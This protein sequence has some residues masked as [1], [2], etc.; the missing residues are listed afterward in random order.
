M[1]PFRPDTLQDLETRPDAVGDRPLH[2]AA[3]TAP[4]P[5]APCPVQVLLPLIRRLFP[6]GCE[7][8][9]VQHA[10]LLAARIEARVAR[11]RAEVIRTR[12]GTATPAVTGRLEADTTE[13]GD[14]LLALAE[15][16]DAASALVLLDKAGP[17]PDLDRLLDSGVPELR[18]AALDA[19]T[20]GAADRFDRPCRDACVAQLG[21]AVSRLPLGAMDRTSLRQRI[22]EQ[23]PPAGRGLDEGEPAFLDALR[24]GDHAAAMSLLAASALVPRE[25][26]AATV[27]PR[28]QRG[29][30]SLAWK[31]GY[32]MRAAVLL[33]AQLAGVAPDALLC[34]NADGGC[35]LGR[36]EMVWQIGM[37]SRTL[38]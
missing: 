15:R 35:P 12:L 19:M 28:N 32:S 2:P 8:E 14:L 34:A 11:H 22:L 21:G 25:L 6:S 26:V 38:P 18:E 30:V 16:L 36:G 20:P 31:A 27:A 4:E 23:R 33:Q 1:T 5:R 3:S 17:C 13:L 29:L 10:Q 7:A 9:A 37:L 24:R